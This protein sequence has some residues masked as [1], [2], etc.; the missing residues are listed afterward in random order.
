[1]K[2][3][4]NR[5]INGLEWTQLKKKSVS[6]NQLIETSKLKTQRKKKKNEN[7]RRTVG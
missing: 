7:G 2:N 3:T 5:L 4:F 6:L 1:M